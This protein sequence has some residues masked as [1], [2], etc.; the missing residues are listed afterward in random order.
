MLFAI[1]DIAVISATFPSF[2]NI[3]WLNFTPSYS[4]VIYAE[5]LLSCFKS[6]STVYSFPNIFPNFSNASFISI[7]ASLFSTSFW[8]F[9]FS[10]VSETVFSPSFVVAPANPLPLNKSIT[11]LSIPSVAFKATLFFT[12][13]VSALLFS[14]FPSLPNTVASWLS[15]F[16][17]P[18]NWL[19]IFIIPCSTVNFG[20]LNAD[21]TLPVAPLA[22]PNIGIINIIAPV[23]FSLSNIFENTI[24]STTDITN[25]IQN[26]GFANID[27]IP[28][29]ANVPVTTLVPTDATTEYTADNP[30]ISNITL[31]IPYSSSSTLFCILA[32][33]TNAINIIII[34][35][36]IT[37]IVITVNVDTIDPKKATIETN[38]INPNPPATY[39]TAFQL[40][41]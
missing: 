41:V 36:G 19:F 40:N 2:P 4:I 6:F 38:P 37:T 8:A 20:P 9:I 14:N 16:Q 10:P 30:N 27:T 1:F 3:Y 22:N 15:L 35:I 26:T 5:P 32:N 29:I 33:D 21:V 7:I 24:P 39:P 28:A 12:N 18:T 17:K 11:A 25:A 13:L 23:Y 31:F 34:V